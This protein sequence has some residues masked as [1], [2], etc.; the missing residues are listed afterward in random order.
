MLTTSASPTSS[1]SAFRVR[2]FA[3]VEL[4]WAKRI[5]RISLMIPIY[6]LFSF[7]SVLA[8][9]AEVY[10]APWLDVFQGW[11]LANF[12]LLMCEFVSPSDS[13]RDVFFA[14]L[15][16]P[17]KKGKVLDG[18]AWYRVRTSHTSPPHQTADCCRV[19]VFRHDGS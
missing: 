2:S 6:S 1:I 19:P 18:V 4:T 10:L 15:T 12:F 9:T 11:A 13:Q 17:N 8:P 16:I 3:V 7:L 14:G 5:L